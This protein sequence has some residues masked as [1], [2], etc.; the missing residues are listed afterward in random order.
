MTQL[1]FDTE[2]DDS[3]LAQLADCYDPD[4]HDD[5]TDVLRAALEVYSELEN[6]EE[7]RPA[8]EGVTP[9]VDPA[10]P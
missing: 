1:Q 9:G 6:P 3:L 10:R 8:S 7:M 5:L 2:L 4:V